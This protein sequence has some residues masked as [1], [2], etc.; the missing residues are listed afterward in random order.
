MFKGATSFNQP[1]GDW[2]TSSVTSMYRMF[3]SASSFNQPIGALGCVFCWFDGVWCFLENASA[4]NQDIRDWNITSLYQAREMFRHAKA[5]INPSGIGILPRLQNM[6]SMFQ[7]ATS[8][9][10][11]L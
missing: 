1:I 5:L 3:G 11:D 6:N 9:N 10:Q 4:F 2:N 8:F 7:G